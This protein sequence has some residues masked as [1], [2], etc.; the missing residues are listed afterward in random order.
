MT[1]GQKFAVYDTALEAVADNTDW[2]IG[3]SLGLF[4]KC[5]CLSALCIVSTIDQHRNTPF[6]AIAS[7][8]IANLGLNFQKLAHSLGD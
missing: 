6:P 1:S 3:V 5:L 2:I 8:V 4:A 7:S